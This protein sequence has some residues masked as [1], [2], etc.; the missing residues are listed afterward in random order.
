MPVFD[1]LFVKKIQI[2]QGGSGSV[3]LKL[4][5]TNANMFG[6]SGVTFKSITGF[7]ENIDKA[8]IDM[9]YSHSV[10]QLIGPYKAEGKI[11]IL[12]VQGT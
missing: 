7:G 1:P 5:L 10:F 9:K 2:N 8:K 11:L 4:D 12:P 3:V 6:F